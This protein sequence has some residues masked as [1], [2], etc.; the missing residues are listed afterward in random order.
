MYR[1]GCVVSE[2]GENFSLGQRQLVCIARALLRRAR[3]IVLVSCVTR[4]SNDLAPLLAEFVALLLLF[5]FLVCGVY[6]P[7]DVDF[8]MSSLRAA[9][10][11][12]LCFLPC[13]WST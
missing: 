8:E 4:R 9:S 3:I 5:A 7:A 11:D 13:A 12:R 10:F 6:V 1:V 2:G